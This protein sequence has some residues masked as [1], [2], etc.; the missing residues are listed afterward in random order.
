MVPEYSPLKAA[1][2]VARAWRD[3]LD[4]RTWSFLI[5][6]G[7]FNAPTLLQGGSVALT[8][9]LATVTFDVVA[10]AIVGAVPLSQLTQ[11]QFRISTAGELYNISSY[12]ATTRVLTLDRVVLEPTSPANAS[13][14]I[15]Q[16][17]FP[18]PP[19]AM[20]GMP[21]GAFDFDRWISVVDPINGFRLRLAD[22]KRTLDQFDPQRSD[23]S[24]A[25]RI[26]NYSTT[27]T[28]VPL[29]EFW[30]HPTNGQTFIACFKRR[31]NLWVQGQHPLPQ[32]IPD[33]LVLNRT[34][35]RYTYQWAAMNVGRFPSLKGTNWLQMIR[36]AQKF[37]EQDLQMAKLQDDNVDLQSLVVPEFQGFWPPGDAG[38]LQGHS[39][40]LEPYR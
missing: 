20:A 19:Q 15:Y 13:W 17:Y 3:V 5:A 32:M 25:Y 6:F 27:S 7:G 16:A 10:G 8:T 29:Y 12:N 18:P 14:M 37:Y 36:D 11:Y 40:G 26:F 22:G 35:F 1:K 33:S 38:F 30:P 4:R 9:G 23:Q 34:L 31:G 28:G 24:L 2:D 21:S 39:T